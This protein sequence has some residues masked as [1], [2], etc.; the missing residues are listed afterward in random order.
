MATDPRYQPIT[1]DE[2]LAM[3]FGSDRKFELSDGVIQMMTGGSVTHSRVAGNIYFALRSRLAGT[4]C[5]PFNSDVGVRV[6]SINVRYPDVSVF[7]DRPAQDD[8]HLLFLDNPRVIFEILSPTTTTID[9]GTKLD[10]YR[11]LASLDTI[12]FVDP[13]NRLTRTCQ[14][15]AV[16]EWRDSTFAQPHDVSLPALGIELTELEIFGRD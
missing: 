15:V 3:D 7:C 9:Q 11:R 8:D 13:V 1:A 12:V 6:D 2:F 10:E 14:R 4:R 16:D 5:E